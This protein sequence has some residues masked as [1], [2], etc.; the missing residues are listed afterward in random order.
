MI[1]KK[2][3]KLID[4]SKEELFLHE[5]SKDAYVLKEYNGEEYIF[6]ESDQVYYYLNEFFYKELS[7]YEIKVYAKKGYDLVCVYKSVKVGYYYFF[8]SINPINDYDRNL[9]DK[10][11][12]VLASKQRVDRFSLVVFTASFT[13]FSYWYFTTKNE[14]YIIILLLIV[15]LGGYYGNIYLNTIKRLAEYTKIILRE[16]EE[17]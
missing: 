4:D 11:A 12:L 2:K 10:H 9:E 8:K 14:L 5:M 13:L 7:N 15:L 17:E 6:E 1:V 16:K 3:F